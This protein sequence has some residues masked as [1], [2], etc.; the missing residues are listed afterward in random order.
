M[1]TSW[2]LSEITATLGGEGRGADVAVSRLSALADAGGGDI[3]FLSNPKFKTDAL[4]S[5]A[6]ILIVA[7]KMAA[8]FAAT[9]SLIVADDP[10]LYFARV[11]RLLHPLQAASAGIHPT[12]VVDASA[13]IAPDCEIGAHVVIGAN[14]VM[15]AGCRVL[16]GCVIENDCVLGE[17]CLLHPRV[18]L[19][20]ACRL[21]NRVVLHSGC[22]IG[23]DGFGNAWDKQNRCWYKIVQMGAV[24]I[25]DDVEIGANTTIDRGALADTEIGHGVRIDNLVQIAHNV[26]IGAHT[27]I[28]ACVGIAGSTEIGAYC[29]IGGAAMFVGHIHIADHTVIGGGTLVSHSIKE[30]GHYA[31]SYPLQQHKDWVRNAVHLRHLNECHKKIRK[32]AQALPETP[33]TQE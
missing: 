3:S 1:K 2:L 32:L 4:A 15:G 9:R 21:G 25:G 20:A 28:A 5:P 26:K 7:P 10:Y 33:D 19:Y 23:A 18:T 13:R 16:A 12:A 17:G 24:Q 6:G 31:S 14:V 29:I 27:A 8:E 22:V 30:A 11:A